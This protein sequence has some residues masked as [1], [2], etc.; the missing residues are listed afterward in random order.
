MV[1]V[2]MQT[3]NIDNKQEDYTNH[4]ENDDV[5]SVLT[6]KTVGT[7]GNNGVDLEHS[8]N[9]YSADEVV[10]EKDT[11]VE[12]GLNKYITITTDETSITNDLSNVDNSPKKVDEGDTSSTEKSHYSTN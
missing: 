11:K 10:D 3:M 5:A 8:F 7:V 6:V 9:N 12:D 1:K 2:D 4:I